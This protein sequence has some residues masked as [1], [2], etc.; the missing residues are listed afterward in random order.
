MVL[1]TLPAVLLLALGLPGPGEA[2]EGDAVDVKVTQKHLQ[3]L[4][5]DGAPVTA[6]RRRWRLGLQSHSLAFTMRNDPRPGTADAGAAPGI[7][8]I[9]FTPEAGHRYEIETRAPVSTYGRRVWK[10]GEWKPVVRDR[11]VD[12]V[13]SSDPEWREAACGP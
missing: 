13:V 11:T 9:S 4:C 12:R 1:A 10:Q 2:T 3:P 8:V 5:L 7:A 6:G